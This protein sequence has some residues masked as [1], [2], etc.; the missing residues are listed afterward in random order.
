MSTVSKMLSGVLKDQTAWQSLCHDYTDHVATT[1][2]NP[3]NFRDFFY[4]TTFYHG[5]GDWFTYEGIEENRGE[6]P[7]RDSY[8]AQRKDSRNEAVFGKLE[9][10]GKQVEQLMKEATVGKAANTYSD[11]KT[12]VSIPPTE[13][14]VVVPDRSHLMPCLTLSRM[15]QKLPQGFYDKVAANK[16][17]KNTIGDGV[18]KS[19][20]GD[21]K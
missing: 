10:L 3:L 9:E 8:I 7:E 11:Y 16:N 5:K 12:S 20:K 21:K 13:P 15:L 19:K 17:N 4:Q 1:S 6:K 18:K 2:E 14:L